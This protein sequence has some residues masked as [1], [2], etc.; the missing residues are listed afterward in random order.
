MAGLREA[1]GFGARA[2]RR[3]HGW[4]S[5]AT[6]SPNVPRL[7]Y[8]SRRTIAPP[9]RSKGAGGLPKHLK[10]RTITN[11]VR[12]TRRAAAAQVGIGHPARRIRAISAEG[13]R[14]AKA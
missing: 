9:R 8:G 10:A 2:Y 5:V 6:H 7:K 13:K 11:V 12:R 3:E 4:A 14:S 1:A